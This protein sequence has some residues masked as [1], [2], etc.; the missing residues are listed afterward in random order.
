MN[1]EFLLQTTRI[2][3]VY[4][5]FFCRNFY[6]IIFWTPYP[7]KKENLIKTNRK[8]VQRYY[9]ICIPSLSDRRSFSF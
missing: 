9:Q 7:K 6:D 5:I 8:G 2:T 3:I 4:K 1:N